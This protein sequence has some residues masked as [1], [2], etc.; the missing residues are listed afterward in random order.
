MSLA[1]GAPSRLARPMMERH[2]QTAR[3]HDSNQDVKTLIRLLAERADAEP[4]IA[5]NLPKSPSKK[6][7]I[8]LDTR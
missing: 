4:H 5:S 2:H 1:S 3:R 8:D 7:S 6:M